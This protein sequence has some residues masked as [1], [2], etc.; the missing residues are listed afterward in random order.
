MNK[1]TAALI[2]NLQLGMIIFFKNHSLL[3][4]LATEIIMSIS[5]AVFVFYLYPFI[6]LIVFTVLLVLWVC[7]SKN[8]KKFRLQ[9][10]KYSIKIYIFDKQAHH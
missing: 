4:N 3:L 9:T 10:W 8:Y 1:N 6:S 5:L 2:R 7:N